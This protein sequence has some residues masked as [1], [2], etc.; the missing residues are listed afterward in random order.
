ML[1]IDDYNSIFNYLIQEYGIQGIYINIITPPMA[2]SHLW[3]LEGEVEESNHTF[4]FRN[5]ESFQTAYVRLIDSQIEFESIRF[6]A[7][8]ISFKYYPR[9]N[10]LVLTTEIFNDIN[11]IQNIISQCGVKD[12]LYSLRNNN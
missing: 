3:D 5:L 1:H 4:V 11:V 6:Q 8:Y 9:L 2:L 10:R 12:V 7:R